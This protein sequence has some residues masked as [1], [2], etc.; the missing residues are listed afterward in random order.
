MALH[1]LLMFSGNNG[2]RFNNLYGGNPNSSNNGQITNA[3]RMMEP[4]NY[5]GNSPLLNGAQFDMPSQVIKLSDGNFG[6]SI[7]F[8]R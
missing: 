8:F 2:G 7:V 3:M 5:H 1:H 6:A 4:K